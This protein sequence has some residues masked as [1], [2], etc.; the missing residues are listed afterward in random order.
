MKKVIM[1]LF[2]LAIV[3]AVIIAEYP[4]L[5]DKNEKFVFDASEVEEFNQSEGYG[6]IVSK[7]DIVLEKGTTESF[8]IIFT[9]P[10][11]SSIREYIHCEDQADIVT[12]KYSMYKDHKI[13]VEVDALKEGTTEIEI[14]D[15]NY[16]NITK[17]VKV[18]V[19]DSKNTNSEITKELA[20]EGIYNYCH[21]E[22]DWTISEDNPSIMYLEMGEDTKNGYKVIFRSYTGSFVYFYVNKKDGSVRV[23]EYNPILKVEEETKS[24]NIYDYL[25]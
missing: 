1:G 8:D 13:T 10:D 2:L 17:I 14:C 16:R 15:Y 11:E 3:V 22:Y 25:N 20:Y 21:S 19:I 12:V 5:L 7:K 6:I 24:I 9:N 4:N 23:T 18:T